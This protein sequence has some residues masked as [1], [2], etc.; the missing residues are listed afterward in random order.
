MTFPLSLRV[1]GWRVGLLALLAGPAGGQALHPPTRAQPGRPAHPYGPAQ[2]PCL[3][4]KYSTSVTI[5]ADG[6]PEEPYDSLRVYTY[7]SQ[8]PSLPG[9]FGA[10]AIGEMLQC[11]LVV[12][13]EARAGRVEGTVYVNFTVERSGAVSG[14]R[15]QK[16]LSPACNA[17][18]LAAVARL[19]CLV[20]GR[21]H[22]R[23][24]AVSL[25]LALE[26]W[27]PRHL[28]DNWRVPE[29]A[30][31]PAPGLAAY[32]RRSRRLPAP[33]KQDKTGATA[34]VSFV[35]GADGCVRDVQ[36]FQSVGARADQ[37][38]MRLARV[39]PRWRPARNA[40]G[41]AVA[42]RE[43][44]LLQVPASFEAPAPPPAHAGNDGRG[45]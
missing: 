19:P 6:G 30:R 41:Q 33:S 4:K 7:L 43:M 24:A 29:A 45:G 44:L 25:V 42:A 36:I 39:M 13:A 9:G 22:D 10:M 20:P 23:P 37:E 3:S 2:S 12:P 27:G 21:Q 40:Q 1:F 34:I 17:E 28:Y 5:T 16:G 32:V 35:V 8:M 15:I 14:A 38:A 31:F 26:F 18:A 11:L